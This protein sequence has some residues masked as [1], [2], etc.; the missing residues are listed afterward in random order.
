MN[1]FKLLKPFQLRFRQQRPLLLALLLAG[2]GGRPAEVAAQPAGGQATIYTAATSPLPA[3]GVGALAYDARRA[4]LWVGTEG[5]LAVFEPQ[6]NSWTRYQA[7][8]AGPLP[9]FDIRSLALDSATGALWVGTFDGLGRYSHHTWRTWK[10]TTSPLPGEQVRA[11][12]PSPDGGAWVGTAGGLAHLDSTGT[13][14]LVYTTTNSPLPS[15][16]V[17]A[18]TLAP[19][20]T[21]WVGTIN[22][23]L[24]RRAPG[25]SWQVYTFASAHL[26]DNTVLALALDS[27]QRP[28][29]GT[30]AAGLARYL[31]DSTWATY[32]PR[33]SPNPAATILALAQD[34]AGRWW[35]GSGERG[36]IGWEQGGWHAFP[37]GSTAGLPDSTVRA[38][39]I[40]ASGDL[41]L[42]LRSGGLAHWRPG[43]LGL[44]TGSPTRQSASGSL[45]PN[46]I[47]R[48]QLVT[49]TLP[50]ANP[51]R[52]TM[53]VTLIA[54]SGTSWV[55]DARL[56][57]PRTLLCELPLLPV[58]L[59]AVRVCWP[60]GTL[61]HRLVVE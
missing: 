2:S 33:T 16:N 13:Q 42:G 27:L 22:G 53:Q 31:T 29:L 43:P 5:G 21:L 60:G 7:A 61:A 34:S 12:A 17:A 25:G 15:N 44:G 57:S 37:Y 54:A 20:G 11:L 28:V 55:L 3:D 59:Y 14:W 38:V 45:A 48:G 23:G 24:A 1:V 46:P 51:V 52:G 8:P 19:D 58:G 35:L 47:G 49:L 50:V 10:T 40:G 26:P 4:Q 32:G 18:L 56:T 9:D 30:A 6:A 39:A 36:L 41:W